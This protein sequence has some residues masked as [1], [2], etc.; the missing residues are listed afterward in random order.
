MSVLLPLIVFL[1]FILVLNISIRNNDHAQ[2]NVEQLF[3]DRELKA[4]FT[5]RKDISNLDYL[6]I[7]IE[8]IPQNLHT[9][10]EKALV[11]LSECKMLNLTGLTNTDLKLEYGAANLEE[12]SAYDAN[13]T[14]F[15]QNVTVYT[16]ELLDAGQTEDARTLLELAASY[17]ADASPIYT[18]LADL[19]TES[20]ESAKIETLIQSAEEMNSLS[21]N[22]II[23]KLNAYLA[24]AEDGAGKVEEL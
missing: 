15:V 14:E 21:K 1:A 13:F 16:K 5:R 10:A 2:Q 3:W 18:M 9:D 17:H 12:L 22:I 4:N 23:N 19:Y 7:S 20:G 8:K 24:P 6:T 11:R